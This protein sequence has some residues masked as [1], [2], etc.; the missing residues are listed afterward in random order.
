MDVWVDL[1]EDAACL[2]SSKQASASETANSDHG[3]QSSPHTCYPAS[4]D[5]RGV[6]SIQRQEVD[7]GSCDTATTA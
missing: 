1:A 3:E 5:T 2:W 6:E 4:I 7:P